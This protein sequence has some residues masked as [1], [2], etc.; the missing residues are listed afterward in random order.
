MPYT[1]FTKD[2][3]IALQVMTA[4]G[5]PACYIAVILGKHLSSV[6]RELVWNSEQGLYSGEAAQLQAEQR[7]T[8]SKRSPK[9]DNHP[10]MATVKAWFKK[11]YC[12]E[13]IGGRLKEEY[14]EQAEMRVSHETIY[15]LFI[16]G[17]RPRPGIEGSFSAS[18]EGREGAERSKRLSGTD[19]R[20]KAYRS[21]AYPDG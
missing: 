21:T 9:M 19:S 10:L 14:P 15:Q 20:P 7:R 3:R 12:P 18:T 11:N 4:M 6:Y 16:R 2:E 5:L 8:Q 1:H 17:N 13:Q